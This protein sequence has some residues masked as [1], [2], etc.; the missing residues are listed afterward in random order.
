MKNLYVLFISALL[1]AGNFS[2]S[3]KEAR[4]QQ[5]A[6]RAGQINTRVDNNGYW[7]K[8]AAL[9]LHTLN[10]VTPVRPAVYN[11]SAISAYSVVTEDSP[12][13]AVASSSSTQS[14]N[15]IFVSPED[16]QVAVN[17]N[18]ST[19][20]PVG[21]LYGAN[22]TETYDGGL[23]WDGSVVG[24]GGSNSGDPV[25]LV[26]LDGAYYIGA[27][28]NSGGQQVSKSTNQGGT[29]TVYTVSNGGGG[30]LDK[31]HMWI[32][33]S[34]SSPFEGYLYD[35]WTDF[36]GSANNNI[37]FSRSTNGGTTWSSQVNV[38]SA[39]NAGS[40]C[41]GVNINSGPDGEVYVI[42]AIYDSWPIDEN[43]IGM[44]RSFDGGATFEPAYRLI[45]DIRGIRDSG[46]N[47][48]MRNNSFPSMA[49]DISGGDRNGNIYIVWSNVGFPGINNGNDVDVYLIRSEDQGET[50]STPVKVNQDPSGQG[51]KHYFPWITCDPENGILSVI[52]YD[53]RNVG[54]D[55][56]EVYCANSFDGGETWEDFK[57]SDVSFTPSPIPGLADGYMGDYLGIN[58]RGGWVYPAWADN[59]TGSVMTYVSPYQTNPLT[60]PENLVAFVT[61][62]TGITD[63]HWSYDDAPSFDYFIIY[64]DNVAV[65]IAYDTLYS[66]PLP[67]YGVYTY[68]VTAMYTDGGESGSSKATVQWGDA[69]I[70]VNPASIVEILMPEGTATRTVSVSNVGQ[71]DLNYNITVFIPTDLSADPKSYCSADGT[72][73][74]YISRVQ[75]NEI[76][77]STDCTQYGDYTSMSTIMNV[78]DTYQMVITNGNPVYP[79]DECG[80][81]VD[82]NQ[83]EVFDDNESVPVSGTP[84]VGPYTADITPP[85]GSLSGSTRLRVRITYA[86]TPQPCGSTT[87]GEVEDY[88][89][90][91]LSWLTATPLSGNIPVGG[92]MDIDVTLS[93]VDMAMG[94]YTAEMRIFSNDPDNP[95]VIVPI[96]MIVSD[97]GVTITAD[98]E[99]I[100]LGESAYLASNVIGGSGNF[101]YLW[102]SDPPGFTSTQPNVTVTP[103]VTTTYFLEVFDGSATFED[104][105]TI[106]VKPLPVVDLGPDAAICQ[107]ET[108]TLNAGSGF[109]AYL[110]NTGATT[111]TI[112]VGTAGQYLVIVTALNGCANTDEM[113][114]VVNDAPEFDLGEDVVTCG[115]GEATFDAGTGF[116]SY[117]WNTGATSSSITVNQSGLYWVDVT[118]EFSCTKRDSVEFEILALPEIDLGADQLFCEGSSLMLSAGSGFVSYTWSTGDNSYY[119][120]VSQ[121]GMYWVEVMNENNCTNRDTVEI[122]MV[123]VPVIDLGTDHSFCEGNSVTLD[124]GSGYASYL[125]NTGETSSSININTPGEYWVEVSD[126]NN[127]SDLDT[128]ALTMD[129]MPTTPE[130]V[131]GPLTVDNFL[132]PVSD[133]T[134]TESLYAAS[135]DWKLEPANAGTMSGNG[136][137]AQITW[138]SGY[139]GTA[140]ITAAGKNDCGTGT[141]APVLN[142]NV[143]SSQS[144]EEKQPVSGIK[145]F[146]NPSDGAFTLQF[147]S[148]K[149]QDLRF[150]FTNSGGSQVY[151]G[152]EKV[153][154]GK[155]QKNF[156]L[157]TIPA[158]TYYLVIL[159]PSGNMLNRI[160]LI[161]Q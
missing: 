10:P 46:V 104:Q 120:N 88:A 67:D 103:E 25:A 54:G 94:T 65:G 114:L 59:R 91:I 66:D 129:L 44:A 157:E 38:S 4:H 84:G 75:L 137:S 139:T 7:K 55:D 102:T 131:S 28:S 34:L 29:Y 87:Y 109:A 57:V 74:E 20:N 24:A 40:H 77:N 156:N 30:F 70:T 69:Q 31:N 141:F 142:V 89:V 92:N 12:D 151:D 128:I 97:I 155:F 147:D 145:L 90:N 106:Q 43:A 122:T 108:I 127:C 33:N 144:I 78:G 99:N 26:G 80:V 115:S 62:E 134:V 8:M 9:G 117:L 110:W 45:D 158:G 140:A 83:N 126:L 98:Q 86:E 100:C 116:S 32:D 11:G 152:S 111:S 159:D 112:T 93:A 41:Q 2:Y 153:M 71:L 101:T 3:Q 60:R 52:F 121:S 27:I 16:N 79:D 146:P 135:Y 85:A 61:F 76:D 15:S 154:K 42:W 119:I 63:L 95:Q 161:I 150:L 132:N 37:G 133:F 130:L 23:S 35:A 136:V 96:T 124:A 19:Q 105:I 149:E 72:C 160:Q 73:D 39:V 64:R 138:A 1:L 81:W 125:W 50:W 107:G 36:G 118:N 14:E 143:Y 123:P 68:D 82:W 113:N 5:D 48:N 13:V 6:Q 17:S 47:K 49:V 21:S 56:C 58:A 22:S 148:G 18:N 53:D 51:R